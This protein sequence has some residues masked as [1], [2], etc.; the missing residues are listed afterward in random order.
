MRYLAIC[1][2]WCAC[3]ALLTVAVRVLAPTAAWA[4]PVNTVFQ[5]NQASST[6]EATVQRG[7]F[8]DSDSNPLAGTINATFDFGSTG[9]LPTTA[10]VTV[11][12]ADVQAVGD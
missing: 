6:L 5:I 8:S 10:N 4:A 2:S 11:T 9:A 3:G 7:A 1:F 12:S